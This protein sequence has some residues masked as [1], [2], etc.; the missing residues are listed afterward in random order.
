MRS[1][2]FVSFTLVMIGCATGPPP[3]SKGLRHLQSKQF[4]FPEGRYQQEVVVDVIATTPAKNFEFDCIVQRKNDEILLVGYNSFGITLFKIRER[5]GAPIEA[6]S[7]I[8]E[9]TKNKDFFIKIFKLVKVI[10]NLK[11]DDANYRGNEA[12]IDVS[13]E[14]SLPAHVVFANID[15]L[16]VPMSFSVEAKGQYKVQIR[17]TSYKLFEGH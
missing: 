2:L 12:T 13:P 5:S 10:N 11:R 15:G 9:I 16:G 8:E 17:T 7:T 14:N 4:L 6:E 1:L 3:E